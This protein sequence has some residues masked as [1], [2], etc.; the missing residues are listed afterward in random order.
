MESRKFHVVIARLMEHTE[1]IKK[2]PTI[3]N[4]KLLLLVLH[5]FAP[6]FTSEIHSNLFKTDII[7]ETW[8]V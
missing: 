2:N 6:H 3:Q 8:P 1:V 7:N 5:P 4:V